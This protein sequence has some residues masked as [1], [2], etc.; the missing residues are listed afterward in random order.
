MPRRYDYNRTY[1]ATV[2]EGL[3]QLSMDQLRA[4]VRLLPKAR[5]AGRKAEVIAEIERHL[6]GDLLRALWAQLGETEQLAVREALHGSPGEFGPRQ[7]APSTAA[8]P[9]A[10]ASAGTTRTR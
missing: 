8:C 9:P 7:S 5:R 4:L 10:P 2:A 3:D 6:A 1:V